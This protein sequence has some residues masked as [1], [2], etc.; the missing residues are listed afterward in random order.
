[1][2]YSEK[3]DA[4]VYQ[5]NGI[6]YLPHYRNK[7]IFVGPGYPRQAP[8]RFSGAELEEM[9]AVKT[10]KNLWVRGAYGVVTD[11]HP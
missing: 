1:M 5:L 11:Q 2:I 3:F 10:L 6:T 8:Q 4:I 7:E 9:G